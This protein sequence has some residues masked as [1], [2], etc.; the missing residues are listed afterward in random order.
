MS[1]NIKYKELNDF[2]NKCV[3][4]SEGISKFY[5]NLKYSFFKG[6]ASQLKNIPILE[7]V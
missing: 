7:E 4:D 6:R 3:S 2:L 1:V 5:P